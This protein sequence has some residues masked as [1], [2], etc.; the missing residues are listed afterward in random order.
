MS[1][2]FMALI[3]I[4][5]PAEYEQ[6]LAGFDDVFEQYEGQ[7][8]AVEDEPRI[9]EGNW[10]AERTVLIRF[11]R[12]IDLQMWYESPDY[13]KLAEHRKRSAVTRAAVIVGRD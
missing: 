13:R 5:D 8:L 3:D 2:Y 4:H 1:C 11:P 9:L 12:E 6:Y 10:P 7:V